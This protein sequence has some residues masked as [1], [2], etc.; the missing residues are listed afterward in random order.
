[1]TNKVIRGKSRCAGCFSNKSRFMK[2]KHNKKVVAKKDT[3]N[4][5]LKMMETKNGRLILSSKFAICH[6][7]KSRFMK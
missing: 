5:D 2:Q 7:K 4:I 6:S 3:K 1:M